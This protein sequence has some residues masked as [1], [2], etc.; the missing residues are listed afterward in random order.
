[1]V[2]LG[3]ARP[4]QVVAYGGGGFSTGGDT[5]ALDDYVLGLAARER[6][7][8][9]F[10]P[11]ASGDA[12]HYV[13]RFYRAFGGRAEPSH[14]SLFRRQRGAACVRSHLLAQ[15]VVYVGGGSVVSML[16]AWRAHGVDAILREAW[17]GGVVMCGPSA[18][19][20]CW[21]AEAMSAFHGEPVPVAGLGL[22][23]YSN[24][25]HY[26]TEPRRRRMYRDHVAAGTLP[27]FAIDEGAALHFVGERLERVV[28]ARGGARAYRV[29]RTGGSIVEE[30]LPAVRL[31]AL[32][33]PPAAEP[34]QAVPA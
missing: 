20:L 26:D 23:P 31:G 12:D 25:V 9:C 19:A 17:A 16:G 4:P 32:G 13:V 34:L 10:L 22:L 29:R 14:L 3:D 30:A 11:T 28:S 2:G 33:G 5:A 18:G 6:P 24:T 15:D 21:F 27:G 7:R 8:V 1:M